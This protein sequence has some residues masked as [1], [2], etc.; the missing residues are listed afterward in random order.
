MSVIGTYRNRNCPRVA[1]FGRM[2]ICVRLE[3][4]DHWRTEKVAA[5]SLISSHL[6][7]TGFPGDGLPC[8]RGLCPLLLI[9]EVD[10]IFRFDL[11]PVVAVKGR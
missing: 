11:N 3:F 4:T 10:P 2:A 6:L 5:I 1:L 9:C 7:R 8:T